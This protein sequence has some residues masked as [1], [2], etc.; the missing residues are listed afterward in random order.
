MNANTTALARN[1]ANHTALS[2]LSFLGKA[3][4]QHRDRLAVIHGQRRLSWGQVGQRCRRLASALSQLGIGHGDTVAALLPN[5]PAM[6]ELHFA[7]AMLGA[8]L[9][10]LNT[11]LDAASLAFMLDHGGARVLFT[12][13]E[14]SPL[15]AQALALCR[16]PPRVID[17]DDPAVA[18]GDFLGNTNT[19][20]CCC[21]A[22]RPL[23]GSC[24]TMSGMRSR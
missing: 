2:P 21:S 20:P 24:L 23:P 4:R 1:R 12:D 19:R 22:T 17:V 3:E 18:E 14:F 8:V 16:Q 7:P 13:R 10:T 15:V 11:R 6:V 5:V 9:N